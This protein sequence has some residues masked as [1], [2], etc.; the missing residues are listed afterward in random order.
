M[1]LARN[2]SEAGIDMENSQKLLDTAMGSG[3]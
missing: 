3:P 1:M 2:D